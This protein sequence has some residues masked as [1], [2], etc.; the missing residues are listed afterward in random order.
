MSTNNKYKE[1]MATNSWLTVIIGQSFIQSNRL[2]MFHS[3]A[4]ELFHLFY[5]FLTHWFSKDANCKPSDKLKRLSLDFDDASKYSTILVDT[6]RHNINT[7]NRQ[8]SA[9]LIP[10]A[11]LDFAGCE[12]AV[13]KTREF[14]QIINICS[15]VWESHDSCAQIWIKIP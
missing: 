9:I 15:K 1:L 5:R 2:E 11:D 10:G 6:Q 13:E 7:N 12:T 8:H 3:Y 14:R 4:D